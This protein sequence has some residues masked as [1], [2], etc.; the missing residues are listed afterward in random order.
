MGKIENNIG[1]FIG[2]NNKDGSSN[3]GTINNKNNI[4]NN[5]TKVISKGKNKEKKVE[6]E[7]P[8]PLYEHCGLL[9]KKFR[10][11]RSSYNR[12]N[13]EK[14]CES[15]KE[16]TMVTYVQE[17]RKDGK[18]ALYNVCTDTLF[19]AD[20]LIVKPD[21]EKRI[22][23]YI[24][25]CIKFTARAYE[26]SSIDDIESKYSI[27]ISNIEELINNK[28]YKFINYNG[29]YESDE[30]VD[31]VY[32]YLFNEN[33]S[34]KLGV[35]A[36]ELA[37]IIENYS[38]SIY[39]SKKFIIGM[40]F[41]FLFLGS[42]NHNLSTYYDKV[43]NDAKIYLVLVLS[44]IIFTIEKYR[45][46]NESLLICI[47]GEYTETEPLFLVLRKRIIEL[48]LYFQRP[49]FKLYKEGYGKVFKYF[50][51][52]NEILP[53]QAN[54]FISDNTFRLNLMGINKE[55]SYELLSYEIKQS[56]TI[57]VQNILNHN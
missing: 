23:Y 5:N 43:L 28:P 30:V 34:D 11:Q 14:L 4:T 46:Y 55:L 44:D 12:I 47:D 29:G 41:N 3:R 57:V 45:K 25:K 37:L 16:I 33:N 17:K 1:K 50:C 48:C 26:Y 38:A 31:L 2:N 39:G 49:D 54:Y 53:S 20:H 42:E 21:P 24:G 19:M 27:S 22:K 18:Y 10:D 56:V 40:I 51:E 8:D 13:V 36:S 7:I 9:S 6:K 15:G 52:R 35:I 32:G